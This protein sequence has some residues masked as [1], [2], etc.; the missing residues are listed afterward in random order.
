[1]KVSVNVY[2]CFPRFFGSP[3]GMSLCS[4]EFLIRS[5]NLTIA[6]CSAERTLTSSLPQSTRWRIWA[7][8]RDTALTLV[9][10]ILVSILPL[11]NRYPSRLAGVTPL[12]S[13]GCLSAFSQ[14]VRDLVW[15]SLF[16]LTG[17]FPLFPSSKRSCGWSHREQEAAKHF[18]F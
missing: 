12:L 8:L 7:S 3:S 14:W 10:R 1:M 6:L 4:F 5:K 2:V 17:Y 9:C 11:F 15:F 18:C 13:L 16:S